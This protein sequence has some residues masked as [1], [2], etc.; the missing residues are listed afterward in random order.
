MMLPS[1]A[2]Q[3]LGQGIAALPFAIT[4]E[5]VAQ[6]RAYL[7][8]LNR[9]NTVHN[10]TSVRDL[11]EQV[12][13]HVLDCLAV[14]PHL[15]EAE[16]LADIGSGAGL[17]ALIIA[18][19]RPQTRV[20]AVE[21]N[22]KKSAFIRQVTTALN[23]PNVTVVSER[24]EHWQPQQKLDCIISRAMAAPK[25]LLDLTAHLGGVQTQ[26]LMMCGHMPHDSESE[27][28]VVDKKI[29]VSVPLLNA[30]RSLL[31]MVKGENNG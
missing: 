15:P 25:M 16:A 8:L 27:D 19:M 5:Q 28:F 1:A 20:Y 9:W 12:V 17:P 18:I 31:V 7:Q 11:R 22:N 4:D 13:V 24:V 29:S 26:W 21:S 23:L 10:L 14:L 6:F 30:K 2:E 3:A